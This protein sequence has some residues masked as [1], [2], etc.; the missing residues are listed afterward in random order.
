[1]AARGGRSKTFAIGDHPHSVMSYV[2]SGQNDGA[3]RPVP[4]ISTMLFG[5]RAAVKAR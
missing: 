1:M 4:P 3:T 2:C 5:Y